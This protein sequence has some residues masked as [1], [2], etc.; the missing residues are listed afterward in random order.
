T[1]ATRVEGDELDRGV[2]PHATRRDMRSIFRD[3]L[4]PRRGVRLTKGSNRRGGQPNAPRASSCAPERQ[5]ND[6]AVEEPPARSGLDNH[7]AAALPAMRSSTQ[8]RALGVRR[9]HA[10]RGVV[11]EAEVKGS[12][13]GLTDSALNDHDVAAHERAL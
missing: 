8:R 9:E 2:E 5:A 3:L 7:R 12:Q 1:Y 13:V 10:D 11:R 6:D 4:D